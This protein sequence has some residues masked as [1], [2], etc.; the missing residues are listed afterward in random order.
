VF[1]ASKIWPETI[2]PWIF[3]ILVPINLFQSPLRDFII[4]MENKNQGKLR[5]HISTGG[6]GVALGL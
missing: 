4:E 6:S 3:S 5:G 2:S 1:G